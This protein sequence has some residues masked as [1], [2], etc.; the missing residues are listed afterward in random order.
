MTEP[1][2][3]EVI[4]HRLPIS[5]QQ[6][7][8]AELLLRNSRLIQERIGPDLLLRM[9][10]MV[11]ADEPKQVAVE[12]PADWWQHFKQRWFPKWALKRW[13]VKMARKVMEAQHYYP[14]LPQTAPET[15]ARIRM[16][17]MSGESLSKYRE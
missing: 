17:I 10:S 3:S 16:A 11:W 6:K 4:L 8:S 12:F 1:L 2:F 15:M 7:I 5:A 14:Q 13:P 9:V